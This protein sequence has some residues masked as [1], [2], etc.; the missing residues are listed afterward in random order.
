M[1]TRVAGGSGGTQT[2]AAGN[3]DN[4]NSGST[5]VIPVSEIVVSDRSG[6]FVMVRSRDDGDGVDIGG[7]KSGKEQIWMLINTDPQARKPTTNTSRSDTTSSLSSV[8]PGQ[9]V[10]IK[11][12]ESMSWNLNVDLPEKQA[13]SEGA[14]NQ[15]RVAV[16]WDVTN[17]AR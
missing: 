1:A 9:M 3:A 14:L 6:R 5:Q 7:E 16:L 12:G 11:G 4:E 15:C 17:D 8:R 2:R 10:N 13:V